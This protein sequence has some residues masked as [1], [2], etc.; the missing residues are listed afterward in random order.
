MKIAIFGTKP[1]VRHSRV[2]RYLGM[3]AIER[4]HC[5]NKCEN[6]KISEELV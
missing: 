5:I 3:S 4:F 6:N 2:V 1:F